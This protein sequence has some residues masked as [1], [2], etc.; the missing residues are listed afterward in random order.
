MSNDKIPNVDNSAFDYCATVG[1][2]NVY[3]RTREEFHEIRI[4]MPASRKIHFIW[5]MINE[6]K[7]DHKYFQDMNFGLT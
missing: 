4:Q 5:I 7:F 6:V 1:K 3:P 2:K